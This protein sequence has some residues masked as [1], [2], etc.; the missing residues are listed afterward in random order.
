MYPGDGNVTF[1]ST[2]NPFLLNKICLNHNVNVHAYYPLS[3]TERTP[4][5][6]QLCLRSQIGSWEKYYYAPFDIIHYFSSDVA[7]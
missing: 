4:V 2:P 6:I 7:E 5:I 1:N 3:S